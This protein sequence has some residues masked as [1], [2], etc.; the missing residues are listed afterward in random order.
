MRFKLNH[1]NNLYFAAN[2]CNNVLISECSPQATLVPHCCLSF[3]KHQNYPVPSL[4]LNMCWKLPPSTQSSSQAI[5]TSM[6][7]P[8]I[9][10]R[11]LVT[12]WLP[13]PEWKNHKKPFSPYFKYRYLYP[14]SHVEVLLT[15]PVFRSLT[16][17]S[18]SAAPPCHWNN[19]LI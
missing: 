8:A 13:R 5:V 19:H 16:G 14:I 11:S 9:F 12:V 6:K 2:L 3:C 4:C 15:K 18:T 17:P 10:L 1:I 7:F